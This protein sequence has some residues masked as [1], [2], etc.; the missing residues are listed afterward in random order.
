MRVCVWQVEVRLDQYKFRINALTNRLIILIEVDLHGAVGIPPR[1]KVDPLARL[2][3]TL[4][5]VAARII[6]RALTVPP[7]R[8]PFAL[9]AA[10]FPVFQHHFWANTK[11]IPIPSNATIKPIYCLTK[12]QGLLNPLKRP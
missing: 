10:A 9:V 7:T 4:K 3:L 11:A 8:L 6:R 1:A 5:G 2:V 12:L